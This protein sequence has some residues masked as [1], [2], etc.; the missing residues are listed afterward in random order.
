MR[1]LVE[2]NINNHATVTHCLDE[3]GLRG[4]YSSI[5]DT[6]LATNHLD[7]HNQSVDEECFSEACLNLAANDI[8]FKVGNW[9]DEDIY[10]MPI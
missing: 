9:T 10:L 5:V 6:K 7:L 8:A 3:A 1:I 2:I 4:C